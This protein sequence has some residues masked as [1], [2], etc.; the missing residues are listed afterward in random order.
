MFVKFWLERCD[1][2]EFIQQ[3]LFSFQSE[4]RNKCLKYRVF[5]VDH[6][7]LVYLYANDVWLSSSKLKYVVKIIKL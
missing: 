3:R 1:K 7:L 6:C 4:F 5:T 2:E